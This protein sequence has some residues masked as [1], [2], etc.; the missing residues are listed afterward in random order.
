MPEDL[1]KATLKMEEELEGFILRIFHADPEEV[2]SH[3]AIL[4][5]TF[6]GIRKWKQFR[7]LNRNII[8]GLTLEGSH[9]KVDLSQRYKHTLK[10]YIDYIVT[11][12]STS[13]EVRNSDFY[14]EDKCEEIEEA[15][16]NSLQ[17]AIGRKINDGA[18]PILGSA[19]YTKTDSEK[20]YDGWIK[21][22]PKVDTFEIHTDAATY[23]I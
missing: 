7:A 4:A 14:T 11:H 3:P 2:D 16:Q 13:P 9:R 22:R 19:R 5:L 1:G 23:S 8:D 12:R 10:M 18:Q 20:Q 21:S 6:D 17:V 15:D